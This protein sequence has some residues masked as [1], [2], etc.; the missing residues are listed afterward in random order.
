MTVPDYQ[1]PS[2]NRTTKAPATSYVLGIAAGVVFL[3]L[4]AAGSAWAQDEHAAFSPEARAVFNQTRDKLLQL[5]LIHKD[6]R[7]KA[8]T[9]SG[10]LAALNGFALTNYHVVAKLALEPTSYDLELQRSDGSTASAQ[11]V[12][13]DIANDLAVVQTGIN[14]EQFLAFHH[15]PM[16]KGERGFAMGYPFDLGPTIVEGTY[17]G[18]IETDY[19][20]RIH[21]TGP[22]NP[23][24]SGGPALARDGTVFGINVARSVD[25]QLVSYLVPSDR[26]EALLSRVQADHAASTDLRAEVA[27]QIRAQQEKLFNE[28]LASRVST[29]KLGRYSVPDA[30]TRFVRCSAL[31]QDKEA[32]LYERD[33]K[34]CNSHSYLFVDYNLRIGELEF[35][36]QYFTSRE[37]G[38]VRFANLVEQA[39]STPFNFETRANKKELTAYRCQDDFVRRPQGVLR[40]ALCSRAYKGFDGLYDFHLRAVTVDSPSSALVS[41]LTISGVGFESGM[42]FAQRYLEAISWTK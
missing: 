2:L 19:V 9:G 8:A 36:H 18:F 6:T 38:A 23:G 28:L 11:L 41:T 32:R 16:S 21:Y 10:F 29:T 42:R 22:V 13:V 26:A 15:A 31:P 25:G 14:G 24:M 40:V 34:W 39:Y 33:T 35:V 4:L 3:C 30:P 12:A 7:A 5:S 27:S 17:N 1:G 37:L 20:R